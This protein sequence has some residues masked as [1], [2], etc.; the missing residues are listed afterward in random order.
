VDEAMAL[1][2]SPHRPHSIGMSNINFYTRG[3]IQG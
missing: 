3:K 1:M 2:N